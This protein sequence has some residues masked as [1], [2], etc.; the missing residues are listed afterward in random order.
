MPRADPPVRHDRHII[1]RHMGPATRS[2]DA[3]CSESP[4]RDLNVVGIDSAAD[5]HLDPVSMALGCRD[6][7]AV[8]QVDDTRAA[9]LNGRRAGRLIEDLHTFSGIVTTRDLYRRNA[10]RYAAS[11]SIGAATGAY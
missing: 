4:G 6:R 10:W 1:E 7:G 11:A 3:L 9:D 5:V 2:K 8:G